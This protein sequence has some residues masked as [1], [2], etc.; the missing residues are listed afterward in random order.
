MVNHLQARRLWPLSLLDLFTLC[1]K[2]VSQLFC[3]QALPHSF[4]KLP[5]CVPTIPIL[6]HPE[7]LRREL[8]L[9]TAVVKVC[10][11]SSSTSHQSRFTSHKSPI[12][13]PKPNT[14]SPPPLC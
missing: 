1:T 6:V 2:S 9:E 3:N 12:P 10:P 11:S 14:P 7:P 5:G 8:N 13:C 4:S